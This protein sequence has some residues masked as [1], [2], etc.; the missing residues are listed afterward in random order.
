MRRKGFFLVVLA[1]LTPCLTPAHAAQSIY[2][3]AAGKDG[4]VVFSPQ[5]CGKDAK[6]VDT[7]GSLR[8]GTSPNLQGVSDRAALADIDGRCSGRERAINGQAAQEIQAV[9]GEIARLSDDSKYSA[10]NF[11]GA[12]RQNGIRA[13]YSAAED[14]K[15]ATLRIQ[16]TELVDLRKECDQDRL[17]ERKKQEDR[18]RRDAMAGKN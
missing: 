5:P 2:K 3:C 10:N 18:A 7:S 14:R 8:T 9:E 6:Q 12:T 1:A 13:Q 16:R 15:A 11:A 4:G 17:A